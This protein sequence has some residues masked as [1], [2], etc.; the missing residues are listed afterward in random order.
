MNREPKIIFEDQHLIVLSKPPGF[1]S[2]GDASGDFS[3]VEWLREYLGRNYVGVVH[4]LDRNTSGLM[5][6]AKRSK[7]ADRLTQALQNDL[8]QRSYL[9]IVHGEVP[10]Q[11]DWQDELLKDEKINTVRVI[12]SKIPGSKTASLRGERL[13]VKGPYCLVRFVLET[14]R[15]HQ[16][17]VQ[18]SSRGFPLLGD[19]KYR[20]P[21]GTK[22]DTSGFLRPALHSAKLEFPH[23]MKS[24]L[25]LSY[26][27]DLW[28]DMKEFW[29]SL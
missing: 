5:V 24:D 8:L 18:S 13:D 7:A 4:R 20:G 28:D 19:V 15:S 10:L 27:A 29:N 12:K 6:Y 14:G 1:L 25:I 3:L 17:R 21:L 9:A 22:K 2:Q 16:I 11:F 26:E 23:P